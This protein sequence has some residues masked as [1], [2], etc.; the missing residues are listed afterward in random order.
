MPELQHN[1]RLIM[2]LAELDIQKFDNDLRNEKE[3]ALSMLK[4]KEKLVKMAAEQKQ[5]LDSMENIVDVLGQ[6][7]TESSFGTITL[8][9]LANYFSDL[10]RRYGDDYNLYNLFCIACSFALPLLKRAFQGWDPLRNPS[11]KLDEMSMWK[12]L[13]DIWEA[14]TLYTQLVS[15]IVLPARFF[16]VKWLQV[17]Y[18]WLSTTPDFEQIH[19][20]YMGSKGLIPQEL[21]VNENIR[22]QLNIG[23]NMMSQAADGLKVVMMEQ[24]P[25]EAHQRKAAADARKEGAAK[26]TLK[27]V[28]EA[29]AQQNELLFKP[30]PGRMHN[31]Q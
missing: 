24:R 6:V 27:E 9:S 17:L 22:A 12:D 11:H 4:K 16:F 30:K 15:K 7:E 25:L 1:V 31:G 29:Y 28:I 18:H 13:S 21:L 14:S 26:S 10:Q 3:T 2:D 23:L 19:N 20:W 5:Q 8:D